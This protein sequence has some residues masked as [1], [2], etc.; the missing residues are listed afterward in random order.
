M[1]NPKPSKQN[2]TKS[3]NFTEAAPL[4]DEFKED[5]RNLVF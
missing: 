2:S 5:H 3:P 4:K 1:A